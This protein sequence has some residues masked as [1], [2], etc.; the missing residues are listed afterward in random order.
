M[1]FIC[2][3][4]SFSLFAETIDVYSEKTEYKNKVFFFTE[5]LSIK[6]E[7]KFIKADKGHLEYP[8]LTLENK[9][10]CNLD[11][12]L[13]SSSKGVF[14]LETESAEFSSDDFVTIQEEDITLNCL[15]AI[16]TKDKK[17]ELIGNAEIVFENT[18]ILSDHIYISS[19]NDSIFIEGTF[20]G[21]Y[22]S[23]QFC[24]EGEL[25]YNKKTKLLRTHEN[26]FYASDE[27]YT[28]ESSKAEFFLGDRELKKI[29]LSGPVEIQSDQ[30]KALSSSAIVFPSEKKYILKGKKNAPILLWQEGTFLSVDEVFITQDQDNNPEIIT[31]G[32]VQLSVSD[33]EKLRFKQLLQK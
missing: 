4:L 20:K 1:I 7:N 29:H 11:S 25:I 32:I 22:S 13:L 31:R 3:L 27:T 26:P 14:N 9:V 28:L 17:L 12:R 6:Q 5:G 16:I 8:L 2:F 24:Y 19:L 30:V 15:K 10:I 18:N 21:T 33:K 23:L